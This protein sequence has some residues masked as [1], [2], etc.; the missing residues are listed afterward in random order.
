MNAFR[1]L[2]IAIPLVLGAIWYVPAM[3]WGYQITKASEAAY[4]GGG[5]AEASETF[6][7]LLDG[8]APL[9]WLRRNN[10]LR[11]LYR[12]DELTRAR[13]VTFHDEVGFESLLKSGEAIPD[14]AFQEIYV[15][16]RAPGVVAPFC[17]EV[18]QTIGRSC[19]VYDSEGRL[20]DSGRASLSGRMAYIPSY[21]MGDAS[22]VNNGKVMTAYVTLSRDT[23]APTPND[24]ASRI[25]YLNQAKAVCTELRSTYGNCVVGQVSFTVRDRADS[26]PLEAT[27]QFEVYVDRTVVNRDALG[28][29]AET[30]NASL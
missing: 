12:T 25:A 3:I 4:T 10:E 26:R 7:A 1:I 24:A 13:V 9:A 23:D 30:I 21:D 18:L 17:A 16:A 22:T 27:A 6:A 2:G 29:A 28:S 8:P 20:L 15:Q 5:N 19:K 11:D 14:P